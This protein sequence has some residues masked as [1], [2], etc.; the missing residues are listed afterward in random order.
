MCIMPGGWYPANA[1]GNC[2]VSGLPLRN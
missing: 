2:D 1:Q